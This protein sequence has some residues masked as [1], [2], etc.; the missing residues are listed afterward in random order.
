VDNGAG[1]ILAAKNR[2]GPWISHLKFKMLKSKVRSIELVD[3]QTDEDMADWTA[4]KKG[5]TK[6]SVAEVYYVNRHKKSGPNLS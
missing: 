3:L 6:V 4:H 1:I 5:M 2:G